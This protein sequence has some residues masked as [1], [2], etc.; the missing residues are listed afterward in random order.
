MQEFQKEGKKLLEN[1]ET[2]LDR[3]E[4]LSGRVDIGKT[5]N[6]F[7]LAVSLILENSEQINNLTS[8]Q[9]DLLLKGLGKVNQDIEEA[10]E[11]LYEFNR[12]EDIIYLM[13]HNYKPP[14]ISLYNDKPDYSKRYNDMAKSGSVKKD[15]QNQSKLV[16]RKL[17]AFR[18]PKR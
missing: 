7:I 10:I 14:E 2:G 17:E 16:K 13:V 11:N 8:D 6:S 5:Y 18:G 9:T 12:R 4:S 3:L 1:I 15:R